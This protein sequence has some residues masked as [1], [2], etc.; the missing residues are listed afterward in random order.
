MVSAS[1]SFSDIQNHWARPFIEALAQ[2]GFVSGFPNSTFRPNNSMTRAEF[3]A[4]VSK[5]FPQLAKRQY[6]G[7]A[8]VPSTYWA[9]AVIQKAYETG[10]ISGFPDNRF[11]PTDR[12]T[13]AQVLMSLVSGL[14]IASKVKSDLMPSLPFIYQDAADIPNYAKDDAAIATRAKL[15]VNYPNVKLLN[16]NGAATRADVAASIYQALVYLEK[17]PAIA[18]NYIVV[19]PATQNGTETPPLKTVSVSHRREFRGTWVAT[20]WNSD[21]PSQA[22][23]PVGQ[24]KAELIGILNRLQAMNFN[25]L[26]LQVRPEGDALYASQLEPWSGWL[27]GTQ[28]KAPDPYYDPLEFAIAECHKRNIELHAWFN[29]YRA[30]TTAKSGGTVR[31]HITITNPEYVYQ[32]GNQLWMDPGAK[33]IQDRAYNVMLDVVRRYDVDGIHL[34]DYF[35]PYPIEGKSFPDDQTYAAYKA[36]GGQLGLGDWRRE[37]VNKLIQRL[38]EGIKATK[39]Y[40]KFGISPFGIYRPGQPSQI[41]GLDAY[42]VLYADAKKWL[43]EGWVDYLAPQLYWKIEQTAQSYPVLL[44]WWTEINTKKRHIYAGNNV[45]QLDGKSWQLEEISNQVEITRKLISK[46]SLGNI[47]FSMSTFSDNRQGVYDNFKSSV[48]AEPALAP[49]MPWRGDALPPFPPTGVAVQN[50]QLTWKAADNQDVRSWT[51]YK[52]NGSTWTLEQV[53]PGAIKVTT[54]APG[55]YALC[56]VDRMANESTG[57]VV[58]VS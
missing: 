36:A 39:P 47:F 57:V 55:T 45:S 13:R 46:L 6:V 33:V 1:T 2:R 10:F 21:W 23:L 50:R 8:D 31:P 19:P 24:Q 43:E 34:D 35:Y 32:W 44:N 25:A 54:V 26:M 9:A 37:N 29:P 5:A 20:V 49:Q 52:Q 7:F 40:V 30:K 28:G 27:T 42:N 56:A 51:I 38:S 3:A 18:S 48:Y 22:G 4:L 17:A 16:P 58:S 53:L 12:I 15:V 41:K 11:R 14:E